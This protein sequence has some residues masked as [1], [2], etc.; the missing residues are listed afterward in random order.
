MSVDNGRFTPEDYA[1]P[2]HG[3]VVVGQREYALLDSKRDSLV[4]NAATYGMSACFGLSLHDP[5]PQVAMFAHLDA[6]SEQEKFVDDAVSSLI[7]LCATHLE[8][9]TVNFHRYPQRLIFMLNLIKLLA[10]KGLREETLD[11]LDLGES[12]AGILSPSVGLRAAHRADLQLEDEEMDS[13]ALRFESLLQAYFDERMVPPIKC[14]Y[15]PSL[16]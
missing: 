7:D 2:K 16:G 8:I 6:V 5:L 4:Q 10:E 9:T 15:K 1:T 13:T 11:W 3:R 14:I 12:K